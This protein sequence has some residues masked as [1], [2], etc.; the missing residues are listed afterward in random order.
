MKNLIL[1]AL[2][3][4]VACG[5]G[6]EDTLERP[7]VSPPDANETPT[8]PPEPEEDLPPTELEIE[9]DGETVEV[10]TRNLYDV[11]NIY[12]FNVPA[13]P[14]DEDV[15]FSEFLRRCMQAGKT[16]HSIDLG[17][18]GL[19]NGVGKEDGYT[20]DF[21][22]NPDVKRTYSNIFSKPS[23]ELE[24]LVNTEFENPLETDRVCEGKPCKQIMCGAEIGD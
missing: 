10:G 3:F 1:I 21:L 20:K 6:S 15:D 2:I 8:P 9:I 16:T 14:F 24:A 17:D 7:S 11:E 18:I 13:L 23:T 12:T 4:L 19:L 22:L 5:S